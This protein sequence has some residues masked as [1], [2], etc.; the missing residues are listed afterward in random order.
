M[1]KTI[2]IGKI[3]TSKLELVDIVKAWLAISLAFAL[4]FSGITLL[5]G[6]IGDLFTISFA[7]MFLVS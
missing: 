3:K 1:Y 6:N 7:I 4:V 2:K 5:S